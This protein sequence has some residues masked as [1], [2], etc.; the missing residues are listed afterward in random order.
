MHS[1]ALTLAL[2]SAP[3]IHV[4][5]IVNWIDGIKPTVETESHYLD[6][7][8]D[9]ASLAGG[10]ATK[11]LLEHYLER[12]WYQFFRAK[13]SLPLRTLQPWV[14]NLPSNLSAR[15]KNQVRNLARQSTTTRPVRSSM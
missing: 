13:A 6:K 14:A 5:S 15:V 10:H 2:E 1:Q 3:G 8:D 7:G 4:E 12:N 11:E 9:L